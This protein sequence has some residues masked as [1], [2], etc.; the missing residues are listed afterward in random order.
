MP[1]DTHDPSAALSQLSTE[2]A[3]TIKGYQV[4]AEEGDPKL[5]DV[6]LH[7]RDLHEA[8]AAA[9]LNGIETMGGRPEDTGAMMGA[10]RRAVATAENWLDRLDRA[11]LPRI[12]EGEERLLASYDEAL[13]ATADHPDIR[14]MLRRQRAIV[15]ARIDVL[16]RG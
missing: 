1:I 5:R 9:I 8:H 13:A 14:E 3:D 12:V 2:I 4:M 10:V 7:L 16:R 11:A 15:A 6:A